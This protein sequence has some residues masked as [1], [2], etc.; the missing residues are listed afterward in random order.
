ML[1]AAPKCPAPD[2]RRASRIKADLDCQII[3]EG[4]AYE[5]IIRDVSLL[6]AFLWSNVI[7][8]HDETVTIK[9]D[10]VSTENPIIL[11]GSV[12]RRDCNDTEQGTVGAFA[13]TFSHN[14]PGLL[15]LIDRLVVPQSPSERNK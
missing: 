4:Q 1:M 11:E 10:P 15:R 7:P 9:L 5:A 6:G 12:V 14:S 8:P 3:Y 2:R 13:V